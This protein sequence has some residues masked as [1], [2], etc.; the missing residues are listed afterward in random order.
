MAAALVGETH[1]ASAVAKET[2]EIVAL[3]RRPLQKQKPA[4]LRELREFAIR[5]SEAAQRSAAL[6]PLSKT[7]SHSW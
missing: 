2:A 6:D 3:L 4:T 5:L 7:P 1:A